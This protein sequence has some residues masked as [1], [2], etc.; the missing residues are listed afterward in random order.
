MKDIT[1]LDTVRSL[2]G[3]PSY[4]I[5]LSMCKIGRKYLL[6]KADIPLSG[7][8]ILLG[9]PYLMTEDVAAEGRNLSLYAVPRDYHGYV[10][11]LEATVLP[12]LR[13]R[14]PHSR[15]ALFADH[16]P[17]AEVDAAARAGMGVLGMNSLLITPEYGS[18]LFIGEIVTDLD[19][20]SV[21]GE[22]V[23]DF[24]D[25]PPTCEGCGL[26]LKACPMGCVNGDKT[27]CLSALTQKKGALTEAEQK[28]ILSGGLV[29]GCDACQL[30]CPHNQRIID[31]GI[32]TPIPYFREARNVRIS[33]PLLNAMDNESFASRAFAWRGRAVIVRNTQLLE[34]HAD[35]RRTP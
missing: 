17:I 4:A 5:P 26:C 19:Y 12:S 30:A 13:E 21:T 20:A 1:M 11:V 8:A 16:S 35:E 18:F 25:T 9:L 24:P 32:D 10:S 15:F 7:T 29:W 27:S 23:P 22:P 3:V 34:E 6:D 14:Y 28:A 2:L 31:R 33:T